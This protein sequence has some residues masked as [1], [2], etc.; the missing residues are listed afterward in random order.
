[1]AV[2]NEELGGSNRH[3]VVTMPGRDAEHFALTLATIESHR[4]R[5]VFDA[6][7]GFTSNKAADA[8]AFEPL[9]SGSRHI[10]QAH[11]D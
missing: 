5:T 2:V 4:A 3:G 1:V 9:V 11:T 6:Q 7:K 10:R 8:V